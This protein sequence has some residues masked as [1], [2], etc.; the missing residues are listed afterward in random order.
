MRKT[1]FIFMYLSIL[2]CTLFLGGCGSDSGSDP[3]YSLN[4]SPGSLVLDEESGSSSTFIVSGKY[5]DGDANW[6]ISNPTEFRVSETSGYGTKNISVYALKENSAP[7]TITITCGD[8]KA[9]IEISQKALSK[10]DFYVEIYDVLEMTYGIACAAK[11]SNGD[12]QYYYIALYDE[13]EYNLLNNDEKVKDI[14]AKSSKMFYPSYPENIT[15]HRF[16]ANH[17]GVIAWYENVLPEHKYVI[18]TV[19]FNSNAEAGKIEESPVVTKSKEDQPSV[20]ISE[21]KIVN[22]EGTDYHQWYFTK[23]TETGYFYTYACVGS[24]EF[25]TYN[26]KDNGIIL[27]WNIFVN[28]DK[29]RDT[30]FETAFN[31]DDTQTRCREFLYSKQEGGGTFAKLPMINSADKYIQ[32]AAWGYR[33]NGTNSGIINIMNCKSESMKTEVAINTLSATDVISYQATL[34]GSVSGLSSSSN[35]GFDYGISTSSLSTVE[36]GSINDGSFSYTVK[37][38]KPN[39]QYVYKAW[40]RVNGEKKYGDIMKFTTL[41]EIFQKEGFDEGDTKL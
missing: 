14:Q 32:V 19:P 29:V 26:L 35:C 4:V 5:G 8:K 34:N 36:V 23:S 7:G 15:S 28:K 18:V 1:K 25:K 16:S 21:Y 41:T 27:A 6:T 40:C 17:T 39:T 2:I 11:P 33:S 24:Y 13:D 3:V 22:K 12:V 9:T 38:L 37:S 10:P 20:E 30:A 31:E